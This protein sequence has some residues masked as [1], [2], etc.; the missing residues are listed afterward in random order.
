MFSGDGKRFLVNQMSG[1]TAPVPVTVVVN[2]TAGL[3]K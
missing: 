2:W 3:E 1:D